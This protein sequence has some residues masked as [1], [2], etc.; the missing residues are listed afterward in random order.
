MYQL[1]LIPWLNNAPS[2]DLSEESKIWIPCLFLSNILD[3]KAIDNDALG[4]GQ[5]HDPRNFI[6]G[7]LRN[8]DADQIQ[9]CI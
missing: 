5:L 7:L 1:Q 3:I 4:P 9:S 6:G 2:V 8:Q